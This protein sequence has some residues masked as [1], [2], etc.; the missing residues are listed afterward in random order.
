M[1]RIMIEY[2]Q[3]FFRLSRDAGVESFT[4]HLENN[5]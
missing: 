3:Y 1:N 2:R 4:K 5:I